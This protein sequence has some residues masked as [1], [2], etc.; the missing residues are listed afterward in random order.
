LDFSN[1]SFDEI[2]TVINEALKLGSENN[3]GYDYMATLKSGLCPSTETPCQLAGKTLMRLWAVAWERAS[4]GCDCSHWRRQE[5]GAGSPRAAALRE[6]K[7]V[8]HYT[9]ELQDTV[10]ANRYDSCI[11]GYPL[12][13]IKNF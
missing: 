12:S 5:Y 4:W 11:T 3:F 1:C 2:S 13:D 8:V 9:L 6:G 10:I 7:T